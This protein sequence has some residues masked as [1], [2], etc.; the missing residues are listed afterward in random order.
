MTALVAQELLDESD[1][2]TID[3]VAISQDGYS[4]LSE[5]E[6]FSRLKLNDLTLISSSNDGAFA[7]ASAAGSVLDK[8]DPA[9]AFVQA[10]NIRAKELG[11]TRQTLYNKIKKYTL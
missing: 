5:G 6:Q 3:D 8:S 1:T 9:N 4:G 2:V 11:L 10:M 7:L